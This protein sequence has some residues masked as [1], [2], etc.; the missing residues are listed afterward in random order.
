MSAKQRELL[1]LLLAEDVIKE[2]KFL[3]LSKDVKKEDFDL[4]KKLLSDKVL[5]E[6][7]LTEYKAQIHGLEYKNLLK[8]QI[9]EDSLNFIS[10]DIA[11]TYSIVS[12]SKTVSEVHIGMISPNLK[13]MEAVNFLAKES[14]LKTYYYLI[15]KSSFN[16]AIKQYQ[17]IEE[18]ISSA[19]K[20]KAQTEGEE[21][22][23][24]ED[25]KEDLVDSSDINSAPV[26]KI[27]SVIIRHAVDGRASDIHIEP[28]ERES[29]V[30]YRIDGILHTSLVLPKHIHNAVVARIK[31]LARLK[32]DETRVPQDGR[33]RLI[34]SGRRVDFRVSTLPVGKH[35]KVVMR[36]LDN[37]STKVKLEELGFS[38]HTIRVIKRNIKKTSGVFLVT[39]PTGSGKTTTLYAV[40]NILNKEGVNI[41]TL[42][43]PVEYQM[44]GIN[45]SQIKPKIGYN[46]GTGLRSFL[47][48]DPDIIMVGEIRDEETAELSVH[49]G[50]TGH[51][52]LSTLHTNNAIGTIL[53]LLD[54]GV[55][56]F[57]LASTLKVALAQRLA[58]KLCPHCKEKVDI[59]ENA[60][61]DFHATL[62]SV[63][64]KIWKE[65]MKDKTKDDIKNIQLYKPKG[66]S[67][68][69]KTGYLGRL[70][71]GEI[72]EINEDLKRLVE[73]G[74]QNISEEQIRE[75][76]T[77]I[78]LKQDGFLK[79]LKGLT[80]LDEI[81]RV[82]ES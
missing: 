73:K 18:E 69:D 23:E 66:C 11:K 81:L 59:S 48:Q 49:A 53:R 21:M 61:K 7:K 72:I 37:A 51:F 25:E 45:Q 79:V 20:T 62:D 55:E 15:S 54:M 4:D 5:D 19:L 35:E 41:L 40:L 47:R 56:P 10:E 74:N 52:V 33:I 58:R 43:D 1:D 31:V 30:R 14:G 39:G 64:D 70:G 76:Q 63:P 22:F 46:F 3:K 29:R 71:I 9:S 24:I 6:E 80:S 27:V 42:E 13:A 60:L 67:R 28:I 16:K 36:I 38:K 78:N 57:L 82:I 34:I 32:L 2:D 44:E 12:F 65:E 68:C 50:L 77:F 8:M 75:N 26:A 17:K